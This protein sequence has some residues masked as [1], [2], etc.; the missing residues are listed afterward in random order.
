MDTN[1]HIISILT[2]SLHLSEEFAK[3]LYLKISCTLEASLELVPV[4]G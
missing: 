3:F 2:L 1:K 4:G